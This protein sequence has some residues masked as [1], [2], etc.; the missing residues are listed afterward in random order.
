MITSF[1]LVYEKLEQT[2]ISTVRKLNATIQSGPNFT[3]ASETDPDDD[4]W[5]WHFHKCCVCDKIWYMER[6]TCNGT[7]SEA[8]K[9]HN[10]LICPHCGRGYCSF[11]HMKPK[12]LIENTDEI[13]EL[14]GIKS[15][16]I[17]KICAAYLNHMTMS[18]IDDSF[19]TEDGGYEITFSN[20]SIS[21]SINNIKLTHL[22]YVL[23]NP[24]VDNSY[25]IIVYLKEDVV[26]F[27][28]EHFNDCEKYKKLIAKN[29]RYRSADAIMIISTFVGCCGCLKKEC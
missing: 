15:C 26:Q 4:F 7:T 2:M 20:S 14:T 23:M 17:Y 22:R 27:V 13:N 19:C 1:P 18:H 8:V 25:R 6:A 10:G 5:D 28:D 12:I 16:V 3:F 24:S 21:K 11:E 9:L 29:N